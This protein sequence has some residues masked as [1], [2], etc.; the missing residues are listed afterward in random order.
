ME[1]IDA[2]TVEDVQAVA[3]ELLTNDRL[4]LTVIGPFPE[5]DGF[6]DRLAFR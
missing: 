6:A 2:V 5:H 3:T 1:Q 4:N